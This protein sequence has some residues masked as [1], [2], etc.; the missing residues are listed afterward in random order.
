MIRLELAIKRA[1]AKAPGPY[2]D[3]GQAEAAATTAIT[4][5]I[6]AQGVPRGSF[7]V[8]CRY[9]PI[10]EAITY[11]VVPDLP[12]LQQLANMLERRRGRV[13]ARQRRGQDV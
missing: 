2:T 1:M 3:P 5:A 10:T 11:T 12:S 6:V 8:S 7:E 4:E 13:T 9:T